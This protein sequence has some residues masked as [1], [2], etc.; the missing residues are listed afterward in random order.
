MPNFEHWDDDRLH[1]Y[2]TAEAEKREERFVV[3]E[4]GSEWVAEFLN[5]NPLAGEVVPMEDDF[6]TL[7]EE[8]RATGRDRRSAMLRLAYLVADES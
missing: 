7:P 5:S 3:E 2:L 8:L 1:A 6:V 4:H